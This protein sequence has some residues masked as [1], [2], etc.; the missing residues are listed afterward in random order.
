M[1]KSG[2][3]D[4]L[5]QLLFADKFGDAA[6]SSLKAREKHE[7]QG[8]VGMA[9]LKHGIGYSCGTRG[10]NTKTHSRKAICVVALVCAH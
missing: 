8:R 9:C 2:E 1:A 10:Q 6:S 5:I 7:A 3:K 4:A